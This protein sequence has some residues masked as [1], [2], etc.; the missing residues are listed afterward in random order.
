MKKFFI[1]VNEDLKTDIFEKIN[2]EKK[3]IKEFLI[4]KI[5][6]TIED[7]DIKNVIDF[8]D[9]YLRDNEKNKIQGLVSKSDIMAFW[10]RF[11]STIDEVLS[12]IKFFDESPSELGTYSSYDY[13]EKSTEKA[14]K[15]I[16]MQIK[17]DLKS[18]EEI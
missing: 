18:T 8:I 7:Q 16:L 9:N 1:F 4:D 12:E 6:E 3:E 10:E 15:E 13:I 2:P 17:K 5:I 11:N 14:I